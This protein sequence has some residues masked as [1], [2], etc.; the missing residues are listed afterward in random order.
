[1]EKMAQIYMISKPK[2]SKLPNFYDKF[3]QV[4]KNVEHSVFFSLV[5]LVCIQIWLNHLMDD[6]HFNYITKLK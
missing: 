5:S 6:C 2:K 1:M 3:Q 4:A